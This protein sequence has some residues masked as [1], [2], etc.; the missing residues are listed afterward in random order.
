MQS[1]C[2]NKN[3][4]NP[5][6]HGRNSYNLERISNGIKN[7]PHSHEL[8]VYFILMIQHNLQGLQTSEMSL[9]PLTHD[10]LEQDYADF[11]Q[12]DNKSQ[13]GEV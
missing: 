9:K 7:E 4:F 12:T 8:Y 13:I 2:K 1:S 5:T 11:S 10:C 6:P 3:K